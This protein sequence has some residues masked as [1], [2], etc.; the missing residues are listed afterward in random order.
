MCLLVFSPG[1]RYIPTKLGKLKI[2]GVGTT[3]SCS[4]VPAMEP[5]VL[6]SVVNKEQVTRMVV[7]SAASVLSS[8]ATCEFK[9]LVL[10][11]VVIVKDVWDYSLKLRAAMHNYRKL[12]KTSSRDLH[13]HSL[14]YMHKL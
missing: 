10:N 7:C 14:I 8:I 1:H 11:G 3:L 13:P 9:T 5:A 6:R 2:T 4:A 12:L